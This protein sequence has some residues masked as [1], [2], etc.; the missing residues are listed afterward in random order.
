MPNKGCAMAE[1]Q[2]AKISKANKGQPASAG[3]FKVGHIV[4]EDWRRRVS[5]KLKGSVP[6][7]KGL[8]FEQSFG[9]TKSEE[10]KSQ[11]SR[12]RIGKHFSL[13][14]EFKSDGHYMKTADGAARQSKK[15]I[16][17]F[18][19]IGRK[20]QDKHKDAMCA[21]WAKEVKKRDNYTC[22][23]CGAKGVPMIAHH[24]RS[25]KTNR[26]LRF[27]VDNG[28]TLCVPCAKKADKAGR[29]LIID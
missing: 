26:D 25:W 27:D 1:E 19:K 28:I 8:T 2:K 29:N 24:I 21:R 10:M 9:K 6:W 22:Q 13:S 14:T 23:D 4:P 17:H 12:V 18:N 20:S 15:M 5:E 11:M 7:N 3:S 16:E